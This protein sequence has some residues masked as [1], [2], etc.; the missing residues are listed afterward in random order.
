MVA[1]VVVA[2]VSSSPIKLST[3]CPNSFPTTL[4]AASIYLLNP[5]LVEKLLFKKPESGPTFS[6]F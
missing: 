1:L 4:S 6:P 2:S 3:L 5:V